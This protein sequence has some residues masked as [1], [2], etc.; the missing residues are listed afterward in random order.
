M[1]SIAKIGRTGS[2]RRPEVAEHQR[3]ASLENG[4]GRA[5]DG[6]GDGQR[7]MDLTGA[8]ADLDDEPAAD[9]LA[10][11]GHVHV[12]EGAEAG[13]DV[14]GDAARVAPSD[15]RR[16]EV[17]EGRQEPGRVAFEGA[18]PGGRSA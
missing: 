5:S 7:A 9:A 16:G 17:A 4:T 13:R 6:G 14:A 1:P 18:G 3:L 8:A 12:E 11:A 10:D 15:E 2:G